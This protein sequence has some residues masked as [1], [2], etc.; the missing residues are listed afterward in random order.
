VQPAS[1]SRAEK[2]N[3]ARS[4]RRFALTALQRRFKNASTFS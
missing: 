3:S 2:A 4:R 1:N